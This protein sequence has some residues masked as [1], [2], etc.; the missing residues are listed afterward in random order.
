MRIYS[1]DLP[2]YFSVDA[3]LD[4]LHLSFDRVLMD[5][6]VFV[7]SN[8]L[9]GMLDAMEDSLKERDALNASPDIVKSLDDAAV[10]LCVARSLLKG[11]KVS[12]QRDTDADTETYL[13]LIENE[14]PVETAIFGKLVAEDFSQFKPRGHYTKKESL[15]N[16]FAP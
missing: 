10:W 13:T 6:E 2:L 8:V 1:D 16:T 4:A 11:E 12:C 9:E 3:M 5:L 14:R 15:K 7:L